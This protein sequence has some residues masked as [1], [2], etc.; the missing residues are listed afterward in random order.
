[1]VEEQKGLCPICAE[2]LS[3]RPTVIDHEHVRGWKKMRPRYRRQYV[4]GILHSFCNSHV[5][6]RF[7][8]LAKLIRAV[9]YLE[10]FERRK[11]EA[12]NGSIE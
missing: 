3:G 2:D 8:T 1:M 12:Q 4:R 11:H 7:V 10:A 5:V 6:G 9:R